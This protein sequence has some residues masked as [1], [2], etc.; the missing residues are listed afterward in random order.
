MANSQD[1][2][3]KNGL[4]VATTATIQSTT[5]STSTTTGA[6]KVIGGV[7]IGGNLYVG[8]TINGNITG[9]VIGTAST[10]T[11]IAG[12][13]ANQIPYQS[14]AGATTFNSGLTFNGTTFTATNIVVPGTTAS[15]S[16]TTG[17]LQVRGGVGIG[18]GMYVGSDINIPIASGNLIF[19]NS[20]LGSFGS[21]SIVL[22]R[23]FTGDSNSISAN[24]GTVYGGVNTGLR[25]LANGSGA[26]DL[27]T[28]DGGWGVTGQ[29]IGLRVK[30]NRD[31][32]L[33]GTSASTSTTTGALTVVGGVGIGG[34]LFVGGIITAT[35][36]YVNGYAVSTASSLT[37]Q[38][39]GVGQGTAATIN[40]STGLSASV[41]TNVAT[42][43]LT[44]STLMTTAVN[45]GGGVANQIPYQ[46]AAG[47]TTFSSNLVF[48]GTN[49]GVGTSSPK[50]LLDVNGNFMAR[51][52]KKVF[53][54]AGMPPNYS[55]NLYER[56]VVLDTNFT[57]TSS[58]SGTD[59]VISQSSTGINMG[60]W[61]AT[62]NL[63]GDDNGTGVGLARMV[64]EFDTY[65]EN[66]GPMR[67][68]NPKLVNYYS[69]D[70]L[71]YSFSPVPNIAISYSGSTIKLT[72]A[73]YALYSTGLCRVEF[74]GSCYGGASAGGL[75]SLSTP[76][77]SS[78]TSWLKLNGWL[79][80][81][82]TSLTQTNASTYY[83][84]GNSSV[85]ID[86]SG[87]LGLGVTPSAWGSSQKA[88]ETQAGS[89]AA[90]S[91]LV[92][93]LVQNSFN[94]GTG[95]IYKT[96]AAASLYRQTAGAHQWYNAPSGTAANAI[97]FTQAMTLDAS[98][99]LS[100]GGTNVNA[101]LNVI[102]GLS[103]TYGSAGIWLSDNT[104]TSMLL[105]NVSNGVSAMWSSSVLAFGSGNNN[106][107]ERMRL[108]S[109]GNLLVG[110]TTQQS[111]AKLAVNGGVYVNGVV[112]ATTFVGNITGTITG[113][114]TTATNIA[115]GAANQIPYQ[116]GAGST[117]FSS[118]LTF[119]GSTLSVTGSLTANTIVSKIA[120]DYV[121]S[122][123]ANSATTT[124]DLS[125]G[126][127][128]YVTMSATTTIAFSNVP[129]GSNLTNFSIIT[130]NS[131]GGYAISWPASVTWAGGQ[132]PARTTT[133]G[134]SD[135][136]TFFTLN[137]GTNIIGSLSILNY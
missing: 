30:P 51:G 39:L 64:V 34:G 134:K 41:A 118:N 91:T 112:T 50:Y 115:G 99:N 105:N 104:T 85:V 58:S 136:Y 80:N 77:T 46:T 131:A 79:Q 116:S 108:D 53:Y 71:Y 95:Y 92:F 47:A 11:N 14:A 121:V 122:V 74:Y 73:G 52:S 20:S 62:V 78:S 126:N 123:T 49:L 23:A 36:V 102:Q 1:F 28:Y 135:I 16:T 6:L 18:G 100:V 111:G 15:T 4:V 90:L 29:G 3:V 97:T 69:Q 9:T 10:A 54:Y 66:G 113:T 12:G 19:G 21:P 107:T 119:N 127:T 13:A 132:T 129:T 60:H 101:R 55:G 94:S 81:N 31:V 38:S 26:I 93:D 110:Y 45:L 128:F 57:P 120:Q 103:G 76:G 72:V 114:A 37:I 86:S 133:S 59:I 63:S 61:V 42:V 7:G 48:D 27:V 24:Y 25:I 109:S 82:S 75:I 67:V 89:L 70:G 43:T 125:Q 137:A 96:T 5:N 17:A 22:G 44:T 106:F 40:F 98:G 56:S 124:L 8:G 84:N 117:T 68:I 2:K 35:N 88:F 32:Q 33:F 87:N 130:Y 65:L 83:T